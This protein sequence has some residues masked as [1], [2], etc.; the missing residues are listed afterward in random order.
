M[1]GYLSEAHTLVNKYDETDLSEVAWLVL[2]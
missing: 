1:L 2:G